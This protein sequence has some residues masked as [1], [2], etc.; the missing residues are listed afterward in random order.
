MSVSVGQQ[1]EKARTQRGIELNEVERVTKIR[2]KFLRAMEGDRFDELPDPYYARSFLATYAEYLGL[3]PEPLVDRVR[4]TTKASE[5]PGPVPVGVVRPGHVK[6]GRSIRP[7][8]LMAGGVVVLVL[9]G[10]VI[11]GVI[12]GSDN[13]GS[14]AHRHHQKQAAAGAGTGAGTTST[15]ATSQTSVSVELRPTADV[16]VCMVDE[17]GQPA[18]NGEILTP[19]QSAGPFEAASFDVTFGN[20]SVEMIVNGQPAK[21]PAVAQPIG[22]RITPSGVRRLD[23]SAQPTCA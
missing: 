13:G 15:S 3:D 2:L 7:L 5:R 14:T 17:R 20:G 12:G 11:A 22:F 6:P 9:L 19:G 1:L 16:W 4:E 18:V 8:A 21:V 23:P 10:A